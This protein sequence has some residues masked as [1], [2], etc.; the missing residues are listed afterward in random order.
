MLLYWKRNMDI[1]FSIVIQFMIQLSIGFL[2]LL[3]FARG[4]NFRVNA[5]KIL[6]NHKYGRINGTFRGGFNHRSK[7]LFDDAA[8][9][10]RQRCGA[11]LE[12]QILWGARSLHRIS[13][14]SCGFR[15]FSSSSCNLKIY[16]WIITT[17]LFNSRFEL[18]NRINSSIY[19]TYNKSFFLILFLFEI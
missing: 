2:M 1:L 14:T 12:L 11:K 8:S 16:C 10:C 15:I 4:C 6:S 18:V 13:S 7:R 3:I 9:R 19:A 17:S 5:K